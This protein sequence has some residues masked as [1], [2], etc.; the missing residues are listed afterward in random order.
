MS[1][2]DTAAVINRAVA[3]LFLRAF[4]DPAQC[5]MILL[6]AIPDDARDAALKAMCANPLI[7]LMAW[8][9]FENG[10]AVEGDDLSWALREGVAIDPDEGVEVRL[11]KMTWAA[12]L[13]RA[14]RAGLT[15]MS[16]LPQNVAGDHVAP[17]T[18]WEDE[19]TG[20]VVTAVPSPAGLVLVAH[21][22]GETR[23]FAQNARIRPSGKPPLA[24]DEVSAAAAA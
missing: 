2:S 5:R 16:A 10:E 19:N 21:D 9:D 23:G 17:W 8:V 7:D 6:E 1:I 3:R 18:C 14:A 12:D 24:P 15:G 4:S 20:G 13:S 22:G 11:D